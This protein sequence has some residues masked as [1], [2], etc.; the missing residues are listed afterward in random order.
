MSPFRTIAALALAAAFLA[1]CT[2]SFGYNRL[3]WLIPWYVDGYVDLSGEQRDTLRDHLAPRLEWHR[4]EELARYVAL[5]DGI[6]ADLEGNVSPAT[7]RAWAASII[8]AAIRVERNMIDAG[9]AFGDDMSDAQM[10]EFVDSLWQ[11][12]DEYEE[13]FL[14]R[15]DSRYADDDYDKLRSLMRRFLG[16]LSSEQRTALRDASRELQRFDRAW[17]EERRGWLDKLEPTLLKREPGW[18]EVVMRDYETRLEQRTPAYHAA[19]EHNLAHISEALAAV[20]GTMTV[21]QHKHARKEL[22][23]LRKTLYKLMG[24]ESASLQHDGRV[25]WITTRNRQC[26]HWV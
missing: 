14:G 2:A 24:Q 16:R 22:G 6:E 7:V 13:E 10:R 8:D 25:N 4:E 17:L 9:L 23:K 3:D 20:I 21:K 26:N 5:L 19:L 12:Q 18:Q 1:G 15:D 11:R